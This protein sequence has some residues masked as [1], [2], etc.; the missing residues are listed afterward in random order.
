M[1][2]L[3]GVKWCQ[4][5]CGI[6]FGGWVSWV[7]VHVKFSNFTF[8]LVLCILFLILLFGVLLLLLFL[9]ISTYMKKSFIL[10]I[11][12]SYSEH[13][14]EHHGMVRTQMTSTNFKQVS[15][16]SSVASD[17][18]D[19]LQ[20]QKLSKILSRFHF[21][22][23]QIFVDRMSLKIHWHKFSSSHF[24]TQVCAVNFSFLIAF[25]CFLRHT[26]NSQISYVTRW[27]TCTT[28]SWIILSEMQRTLLSVTHKSETYPK[29]QNTKK[30]HPIC[31]LCCSRKSVAV[32]SDKL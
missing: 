12:R 10:F 16:T 31:Y 20:C 22:M 24:E 29:L 27:L 8:I 6:F 5:P 19:S 9:N 25:C 18:C 11:F 30:I 13:W 1:S 14:T 3:R 32:D 26:K 7:S 17:K 2:V 21:M 23:K 4:V 15:F 28:N